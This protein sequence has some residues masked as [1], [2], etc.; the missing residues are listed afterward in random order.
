[1]TKQPMASTKP[2]RQAVQ[3][4]PQILLA[5][6]YGDGQRRLKLTK[7]DA[8]Q[9]A[10]RLFKV[11]YPEYTGENGMHA[12]VA[13]VVLQIAL[14]LLEWVLLTRRKDPGLQPLEALAKQLLGLLKKPEEQPA[15]VETAE[16]EVAAIR[17]TI[18]DEAVA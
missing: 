17:A 6:L 7:D 18:Q 10:M 15:A 9:R 13:V 11:R 8:W 1:M 14:A 3:D 16:R 4:L 2:E 5:L 12:T